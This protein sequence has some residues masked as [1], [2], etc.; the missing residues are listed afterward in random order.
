VVLPR[1][2]CADASAADLI[3]PD[4]VSPDMGGEIAGVAPVLAWR[5]APDA[6]P[7]AKYRLFLGKIELRGSV[8]ERIRWRSFPAADP[9]GLDL[10]TGHRRK[11]ARFVARN[12]GGEYF[13]FVEVRD[14][15]S[16]SRAASEVRRFHTVR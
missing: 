10:K 11:M 1:G 12:P 13:W 9:A 16:G 8:R 15:E 6:P 2:E 4:L 5:P 3:R 14:P 7:D